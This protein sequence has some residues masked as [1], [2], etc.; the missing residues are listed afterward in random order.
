MRNKFYLVFLTLIIF[1]GCASNRTSTERQSEADGSLVEDQ[2]NDMSDVSTEPQGKQKLKTASEVVS[3]LSG[4]TSTQNENEIKL[5]SAIKS[6]ND[7]QIQINAQE[8]IKQDPKNLRALNSLAVLHY[9]SGR[10][11]AAQ[12]MF[13]KALKLYPKEADLYNNLGL[14]LLAIGERREALLTFKKGLQINSQS[15]IIGANLGSIYVKEKDFVKAEIALEIPIKRGIKDPKIQNN[16]AITLA[17]RGKKKEAADLFEKLLKENPNSR[18]IMYNNAIAQID[19]LNQ[20]KAGL[21]TLNRLK[22][23][24][25]P[26]DVKNEIKELENRAKAGLK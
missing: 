12:Y 4:D 16:Y 2:A 8:L 21:D 11:V 25:A 20:P 13:E 3:Q 22:F 26:E 6:Q 14:V 18:E 7:G 15:V 24:G 10:Y 9:K 19:Y 17:A 1:S 23:V 5:V